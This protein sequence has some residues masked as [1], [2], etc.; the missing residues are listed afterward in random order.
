MDLG[1]DPF[2]AAQRHLFPHWVQQR[3]HRAIHLSMSFVRV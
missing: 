3:S 1:N 2:L